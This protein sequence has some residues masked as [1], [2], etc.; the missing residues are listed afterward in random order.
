MHVTTVLVDA[1]WHVLAAPL[2]LETLKL[3]TGAPQVKAHL[4]R[5]R[6]ANQC[7]IHVS[8]ISALDAVLEG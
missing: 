4:F 6:H 2:L 1:N 8:L 5:T 7:D 3:C